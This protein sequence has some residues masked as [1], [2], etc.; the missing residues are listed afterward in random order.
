MQ[1]II[2]LDQY[3]LDRLDSD[4]GKALIA[5]CRSDLARDGLFNL[6]GLLRPAVIIDLLD[7]LKPL[8]A[9]ASFTHR[10]RHN[11][12]FLPEVDDLSPG[13]P[14]LAELETVNHTVC[15]DQFPGNAL[16][17]LYA[18]QPFIDF[19]ASVMQKPKLYPM[20]DSLAC[21]NVMAYRDGEALNWHFDRSEFTTTL[22]LQAA[23]EG[24][25]FEYRT[26]LRSDD[27]PNY[28]G[29]GEFLRGDQADAHRLTLSPGT[30]NV[31][32][33]KNTLHR[34]SPVRGESERIIA[35]FTYYERPDVRF[36]GEENIGFYGRANA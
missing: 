23:D 9:N 13:H 29:V 33:G 15:A 7:E 5:R 35:V 30:L 10:R 8:I 17:Q 14:A 16:M 28:D 27:D 11:V 20:S 19:L 6:A 18:W 26:G 25:E 34:V 21:L 31:F 22:L 4:A 24:G 36:S 12:Y 2:D 1:T 32:R 3:P